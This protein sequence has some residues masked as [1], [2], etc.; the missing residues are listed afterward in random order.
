MCGFGPTPEMFFEIRGNEFPNCATICDFLQK[1]AES[2]NRCKPFSSPGLKNPDLRALRG[3]SDSCGQDTPPPSNADVFRHNP[4][5]EQCLPMFQ[6][7]KLC[8]FS[9]KFSHKSVSTSFAS[10]D[11][12]CRRSVF[13]PWLKSLYSTPLVLHRETVATAG[14]V[15][16]AKG[17]DYDVN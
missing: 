11:I 2:A 6:S 4:L 7:A 1:Y 17:F 5:C 9:T 13:H 12:C 8:R 10:P 3:V 15:G 14:S 16:Y